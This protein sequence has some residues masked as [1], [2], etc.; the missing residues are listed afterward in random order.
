MNNLCVTDLSCRMTYHLVP[1]SGHPNNQTMLP[2]LVLYADPI[3]KV[4]YELFFVEVKRK[5][6]FANGHL[7]SDTVKLGKEMQIAVNKLILRKVKCPEVVGLLV[8]GK[9]N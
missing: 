7:E 2:D 1:P 5:G 3:S 4:N 8:E 9:F 6:N